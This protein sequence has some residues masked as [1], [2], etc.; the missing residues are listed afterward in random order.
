MGLSDDSL[1]IIRRKSIGAG[2]ARESS[3]GSAPRVSDGQALE[4]SAPG[5]HQKQS[6]AHHADGLAGPTAKHSRE[7]LRVRIKSTHPP[8]PRT[9]WY[10][11]RTSRRRS[12]LRL[13]RQVPR[14]LL[15][16]RPSERQVFCPTRKY[17]RSLT[18]PLAKDGFDCLPGKG[19][20]TGFRIRQA[21]ASNRRSRSATPRVPRRGRGRKEG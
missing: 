4:G 16:R 5:S 20:S 3:T 18:R 8:A 2:S 11:Y 19:T 10:Y 1:I 21:P 12:A 7:A 6:K 14:S 13:I 15:G 9:Q 17:R